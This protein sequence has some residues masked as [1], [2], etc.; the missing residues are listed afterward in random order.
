MNKQN[1]FTLIEILIAITVF[2]IGM[3]AV[4][5]MQSSAIKGNYASSG[6]TEAVTLAQD[7]LDLLMALD[8]SSDPELQDTNGNGTNQDPNDDGIDDDGGNFGLDDVQAAADGWAA[9]QGQSGK[10]DVSWNIAVDE[11]QNNSRI[12]KVIVE[13]QEKGAARS[14][15]VDSIKSIEP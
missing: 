7:R 6:M 9:N 2:A 5:L 13:W 3:M 10:F 8:P 11:P 12:I 15:I 1:G 4:A 14:V